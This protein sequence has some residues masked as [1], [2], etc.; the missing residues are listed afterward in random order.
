[1]VAP[2]EPG[3]AAGHGSQGQPWGGFVPSRCSPKRELLPRRTHS[4]SPARALVGIGIS[5]GC[6]GSWDQRVPR[7][8]WLE[9]SGKGERRGKGEG[10]LKEKGKGGEEKGKG[11]NINMRGTPKAPPQPGWALG[12]PCAPQPVSPNLPVPP[13]PCPCPSRPPR[14]PPLYFFNQRRRFLAPKHFPAPHSGN[15]INTD[16]KELLMIYKGA[17]VW[18]N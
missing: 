12:S 13:H 18:R 5:Q 16:Q 2:L 10:E 11:K 7:S 17:A 3:T 15:L 6:G 1:M 8:P 4:P 9:N 14:S